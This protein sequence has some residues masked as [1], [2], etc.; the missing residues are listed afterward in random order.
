MENYCRN[1][2]GLFPI[3]HNSKPMCFYWGDRDVD[4]SLWQWEECDIPVCE[5]NCTRYQDLANETMPY[6]DELVEPNPDRMAAVS[7]LM[8]GGVGIGDD[9]ENMDVDVIHRTCREDGRI[10]SVDAPAKAAPIQILKMAFGGE[11]KVTDP[12]SAYGEV[13]STHVWHD[14]GSLYYGVL[15]YSENKIN[16][17]ATPEEFGLSLN[18]GTDYLTSS[19]SSGMADASV[20]SAASSNLSLPLQDDLTF[21]IMYFSPLLTA[22]VNASGEKVA[23]VGDL[24][25]YVPFSRGRFSDVTFDGETLSVTSVGNVAALTFAFVSAD[26]NVEELTV[27]CPG[28][29]EW[30]PDVRLE[31]VTYEL[32]LTSRSVS[33]F[34]AGG[35][36][37]GSCTYTIEDSDSD[38][39]N[40]HKVGKIMSLL[41][42]FAY[43]SR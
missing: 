27:T 40:E 41:L 7:V 16:D 23:F 32:D 20:L 21:D 26:G 10:L 29:E 42:L 36:E 14:R 17:S 22:N 5:T 2:I 34:A 4:M 15:F 6:C 35:G 19:Y 25:K 39:A 30:S 11:H 8:T 33:F 3:Y 12:N 9:V 18:V 37:E 24:S 38:G 31:T 13:W 43:I 1:P 28:E